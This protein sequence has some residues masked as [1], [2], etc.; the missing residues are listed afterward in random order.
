MSSTPMTLSASMLSESIGRVISLPFSKIFN[1]NFIRGIFYF[2]FLSFF[3][4]KSPASDNKFLIKFYD[5]DK[6]KILTYELKRPKV[7]LVLSGGG[8]RGLS[9]IGVLKVLEKYNIPID[10]VVGTSMGSIVGGLYCAGL[11]SGEIEKI[12]LS[13]DWREVLSL[14]EGEDRANLFLERKYLV[15]KSFL[16]FRFKG[17]KPLLPSYVVSG[18]KITESLFKIFFKSPFHYITNYDSL[19]PKFFS[20]ATDLVSGKRVVFSSGNLVYV[21]RASSTIPLVFQPVVIDTLVLVDG[22]LI[23][24][25]P[26]DVARN[27]GCD[28]VLTVD[29][30]SPLRT[31]EEIQLPWNTADQIVGIMMQLSN[32]FQL[33]NSDIVIKPKLDEISAS[34]FD[35]AKYIIEKGEEAGEEKIFEIITALKNKFLLLADDEP[36]KISNYRL[37][38]QGDG[39]PANVV[40][41]VFKAEGFSTEEMAKAFIELKLKGEYKQIDV[42]IKKKQSSYDVE[43]W[44]K[45]NPEIK[46]IAVFPQSV[47]NFQISSDDFINNGFISF[48]ANDSIFIFYPKDK[49][50]YSDEN[51]NEIKRRVLKVF[52]SAGYPFVK[53]KGFEFDSLNGEVKIYI[54]DGCVSDVEISGNKKTKGYVILRDVLFKPGEILTERGIIQTLKNLW[55]T[56]LFSQ[57]KLDY[58]VNDS[59]KVFINFIESASQFLRLGIRVD[60]ERGAQIFSDF[61]DE[62]SFGLNDEFGLTFQGGMRNSS[63]KIEYKVDR[64]LKTM[65]T[66]RF[67]FFHNERNV[68]IYKTSFGERSFSLSNL[69]EVKFIWAGFEVSTGGQFER[70]GNTLLKY[71]L[72]KAI[73]KN[74]SIA[75]FKNEGNLIGKLQLNIEIDSRDRAYFPNRGVYL[76]AFYETSQK[77]LGSDIPYSK[78]FFYYENYNTYFK[79]GSLKFKFLFGLCDESTPMSQQFFLGSITGINSFSGMREDENFG[80]QI[81][82]LGV[83]AR[84]KSPVKVIF[85]SFVSLRYDIGSVWGKLEAVRW[86]DLRQGIGIELGFDTPIGA[87]RFKV[88]K[89]FIFKRLKQDVLLWGPTV[90]QFSVGFE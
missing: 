25:I 85:D 46:V 86:K 63:L 84:F 22:G 16:Y 17:L 44:T 53:V 10:Y 30:T 56:N 80:R 68:Y 31:P 14:G 71:R 8:A 74:I 18:Q 29:A 38:I 64:L 59:V 41:E 34:D 75:D 48:E 76:N 50:F 89:S 39:L 88:G 20:V 73:V 78:I 57:I 26:A 28:I 37:I 11:K 19:K 51:A 87:L 32:K 2:V 62:N 1:W 60:N 9:H 52:R 49:L 42:K 7:A 67:G 3:A 90:F 6:E 12:A 4:Y 55:A 65:L 69:G 81:I 47:E 23:S 72:E 15:E 45:L 36:V 77:F 83:E 79:Y 5:G 82:S 35:K 40:D 27:L 66:Y 24:N 13:T 61:R 54:T 33:E 70:V 21:V 58:K 43:I